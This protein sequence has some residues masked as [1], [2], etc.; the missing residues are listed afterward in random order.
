MR[1]SAAPAAGTARR[2]PVF[3]PA[4]VLVCLALFGCRCAAAPAPA[5]AAAPPAA[6]SAGQA[7]RPVQIASVAP[8]EGAQVAADAVVII[9]RLDLTRGERPVSPTSL[10]LLLDGEDV[11]A[12]ARVGATED[13][14]PSQADISYTPPAPLA[15]GEHRAE[16]RFVDD[17][18]AAYSYAWSFTVAGG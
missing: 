7:E 5:P 2:T 14:P 13:V 8:A 10:R 15:A 1:S 9:V 6:Q 16:V 12:A 4:S 17:R 11:T 18:G 3:G